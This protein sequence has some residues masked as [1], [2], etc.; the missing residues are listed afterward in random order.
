MVYCKKMKK[1]GTTFV[2]LSCIFPVI[3]SCNHEEFA[4]EWEKYGCPGAYYSASK[5]LTF[6]QTYQHQINSCTGDSTIFSYTL[7]NQPEGMIVTSDG[8]IDWTPNKASQI[9]NHPDITITITD[10]KGKEFTH[11]F[12]VIIR[13]TCTSGNILSIWSGD[14]RASIDRSKLLGS[15]IAY[16]D[17]S[18][19]VKTPSSHSLVAVR[20]TMSLISTSSDFSSSGG[21]A[22]YSSRCSFVST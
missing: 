14:H 4:E 19:S 18:S 21:N 22:K 17:N 16:T 6:G 9:T 8:L 3:I 1:I 20:Q 13:G 10:T 15:V 2:F 12:T 5:T 7:N 11:T